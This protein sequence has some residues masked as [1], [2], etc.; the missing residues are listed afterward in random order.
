MIELMRES[1]GN[2]LGVK[3]SGRLTDD[4]YK[5]TLIPTLD[6][7]FKQHGK[8][9][10]LILMDETFAGWDLDAAWDDASYG[11]QHRADFDRLAVVGGPSWV[12]LCIKLCGFLFKGEIKV[13]PPERI[14]SAWTWV[15]G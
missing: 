4:D 1:S 2:V 10:V 12:E 7:L 15:R 8:L 13:F 9:R 14:D 3:A 6:S 5:N 11:L